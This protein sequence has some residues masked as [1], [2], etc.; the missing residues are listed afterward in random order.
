MQ[1][2]CRW[3]KLNQKGW[4]AGNDWKP[5]VGKPV[6]PA[7]ALWRRRYGAGVGKGVISLETGRLHSATIGE[8]DWMSFSR[9]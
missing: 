7:Q 8:R 9:V 5:E 4:K 6:C 1:P 3:Q 2:L